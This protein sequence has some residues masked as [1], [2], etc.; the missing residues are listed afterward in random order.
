MTLTVSPGGPPVFSNGACCAF[1]DEMAKNA[2]QKADMACFIRCPSMFSPD[3]IS[4][5]P[6]I[7]TAVKHGCCRK[8]TNLLCGVWN[9][10]CGEENAAST[11]ANE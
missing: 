4:V 2:R 10:L 7:A 6:N 5:A 3:E 1:S 9:P 11:H 8:V